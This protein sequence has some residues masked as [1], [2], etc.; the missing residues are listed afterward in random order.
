MLMKS[1]NAIGI[2]SFVGLTLCLKMFLKLV[3]QFYV[4]QNKEKNATY[5]TIEDRLFM[6]EYEDP[7]Q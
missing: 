4:A 1:P 2:M 3:W 6:E 7:R 5:Q